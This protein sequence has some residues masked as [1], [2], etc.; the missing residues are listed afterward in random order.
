MADALTALRDAHELAPIDEHLARALGRIARDE[1]PDTILAAA[2]ASRAVRHGHVC[3]DM[4]RFVRP[5]AEGVA[6]PAVD[7]WLTSLRRSPLLGSP[8][9]FTPLVLEGDRLYLRRYFRYETRLAERLLGRVAHLDK[10]LDGVALRLGLER[11]FPRQSANDLDHQRLAALI[12]VVRR[13]CIISGGPGTGKTTTVVKI[14]A[15]LAE[16]AL[17]DGRPRLHVTLVAPTGKA[18]ARLQESIIEQRAVLPVDERIRA[19]IPDATSTIHRALRPIPGSVSRFRHDADNLLT[20]DVLIVDEAS[21]VDLALMTKLVDALPS[22]AR[23]IL[24]GDRNQLAS[25]EA[26]AILGDLCGPLRAPAF[27]RAF[28]E[29]VHALT[30]EELPV[31]GA[32]KATIADCVV[33]LRRNYRYPDDSG[34]AA[35]AHAVN[36]GDATRVLTVLHERR[37]DVRWFPSTG[38]GALGDALRECAVSGYSPY[39]RAD[40]P[41]TAFEAFGRFRILSAHRRGPHG[42]ERLNPLIAEAL[43]DEGLLRLTGPW[44]TRRPV[45]VTENEYQVGLFNGDIAVVLPDP[46]DGD[47]ARAWFFTALGN[48]RKLAPS[49]LPP[50]ET[51]FAMT[52][53]KAQGSEFDEVAIVLPPESSPVLTRELLYTAVTRARKRVVLFGNDEIITEAVARPVERASGLRERLWPV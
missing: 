52:V 10:Q 48:A 18:A 19:M 4:R 3:L 20:T 39:L 14:L 24:L 47:E 50:H 17:L 44:Y 5:E 11:L 21:M 45:L 51:V 37:D 22:H 7:A 33:H 36:E 46:E 12:A 40:D 15:L 25:V 43:A 27:S 30:G 16:Q 42:V 34:I 2:L 49:R 38:K 32:R 31:A 8:S 35:L 41:R 13:F 9:D 6:W 23:L 28:A 29:H 26:G 1:Q 53:H